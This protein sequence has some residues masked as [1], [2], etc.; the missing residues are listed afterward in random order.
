MQLQLKVKETG[1]TTYLVS[2]KQQR[3]YRVT[4]LEIWKWEKSPI[5]ALNAKGQHE[6]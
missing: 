5:D 6:W 1:E 2:K 4:Y 3:K